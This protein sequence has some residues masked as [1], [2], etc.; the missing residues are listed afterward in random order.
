[1]APRQEPENM[2]RRLQDIFSY[3]AFAPT[4]DIGVFVAIN[5][6]DFG[7]GINMAK[8]ANDLIATLAPR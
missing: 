8:V 1:M 6:F 7:A 2:K 4:H 5:K 3:I